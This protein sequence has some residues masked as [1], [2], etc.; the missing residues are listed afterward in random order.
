MSA[1]GGLTKIDDYNY[2]DWIQPMYGVIYWPKPWP[3]PPQPMYGIVIEPI[4]S[5]VQ[6]MYGVIQID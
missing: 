5:P 3:I 1:V 2:K 6:P 4:D